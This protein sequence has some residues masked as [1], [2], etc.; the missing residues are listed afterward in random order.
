MLR[1]AKQKQTERHRKQLTAKEA[2]L[3]KEVVQEVHEV[4]LRGRVPVPGHWV[5]L[6]VAE[7]VLLLRLYHRLRRRVRLLRKQAGVQHLGLP[8]LRRRVQRLADVLLEAQSQSLYLR[9]PKEKPRLLAGE[10]VE[11]SHHHRRRLRRRQL[12]QA[13][14]VRLQGDGHLEQRHRLLSGRVALPRVPSPPL[15]GGS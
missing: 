5:L 2:L 3:A 1:Q 6:L 11:L 4:A 15:A 13:V 10:Q 7:A 12:V 14:R 9:R 8:R